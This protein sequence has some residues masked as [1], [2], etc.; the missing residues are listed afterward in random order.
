MGRHRAFVAQPESDDA[1][2]DAGLQEMHRCGMPNDVWQDLAL[3]QIRMG[4]GRGLHRQG[5]PE[6]DVGARHR[7]PVLIG[8]QRGF[9]FEL[10]I[11]PQP[12]A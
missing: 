9:C 11:L 6:S 5:Q 4:P 7:M 2:V 12:R 1:D 10:R 8:Q 3:S